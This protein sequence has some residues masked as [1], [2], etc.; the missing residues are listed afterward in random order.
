M[1]ID[2]RRFERRLAQLHRIADRS[3]RWR[4][5]LTRLRRDVDASIACH[6]RRRVQRPQPAFPDALP[7]TT[8]RHEIARTI[9]S[10]PV[11]V[12]C[13]D[14]GSGKT[15][16]LPKI[17]LALG[18]GASGLI[19]HT[20]PRRIAARSVAARIAEELGS[21]LGS[22][23]GYKVRFGDRVG[24]DA[25]IKIMTDGILLAEA[26]SDRLLEQYDTLIIDE[27]H[28][29]SLNIDF[30]LGYLKRLLKKRSDLKVIITSATIDPERF[31]RHFNNAPVIEV[32]GRAY[33]VEVLYRPPDGDSEDERERST[34]QAA[35]DAVDEVSAIDR[36]DILVFASGEREI[37]DLAEALRKHHPPHTEILPLYARLSVAEQNRVFSSHGTRRIVIA[38]NVAETSLTVPG[39]RYVIDIGRARVSRYSPRTQVQRLPIEKISQASAEQRKGRC[40]RVSAGICVRLYSENDYNDRPLFSEPEILRANLAGVILRMEA[41][42]L[43][44]VERFP[45]IDR[46][47]AKRIK[48]GFRLLAELGALVDG[49]LTD[50]GRQLARLPLDPRLGRMIFAA[51]EEHCLSEI[52]IIA[53]ALTVQDPRERPLEAAAKADAC[54][55]KFVEPRSDFVGFLKL[56]SVFNEQMHRLS[57]NKLRAF[58]RDNFLSY[59]RMQN[60]RDTH[61]QLQTMAKEMGFELN[62]EPAQYGNIHRAVLA[63]FLGNVAV[64]ADQGE[65]L[66]PRGGKLSLFPGSALFDKRPRWIVAAELVQTKRLYARTVATVEPEWVE[67]V[68]RDLCRRNYLE[69]HWDQKRGAVLAQEQV[70]LYGLV[71]VGDR[72]VHYGSIDHREA[73][74]I[75]IREGLIEGRYESEGAFFKHNQQLLAEIKALEHRT[76]RHDL[77][78]DWQCQYDFYDQRIPVG[79]CEATAFEHW[80]CKAEHKNA[81]LLYLERDYLLRQSIAGVTQERFPEQLAVNGMTFRLDYRFE[82]GHPADGVT[83][84][85]PVAAVNQLRCEPFDW[86]VPGLLPEKVAALLRS[87]PKPLRRNFVPIPKFTN[88]CIEALTPGDKPLT[89]ALAEELQRMTGVTVPSSAWRPESLPAHLQMNFRLVD[90]HGREIAVSRDLQCLGREYGQMASKGF[91][92]PVGEYERENVTRWDFGD[93]PETIELRAGGHKVKAYPAL[94]YESNSISLRLFDSEAKAEQAMRHGLR[95]LFILQLPQQLEYLR[96]NLPGIKKMCLHYAPIG[97]CPELKHDLITAAV[98]HVFIGDGASVRDAVI[99]DKRLEQGRADLI[100]TAE[101]LCELVGEVLDLYN[102]ITTRI[103]AIQKADWKR[104]ALDDIRGQLVRLVYAGFTQ[105]TPYARMGNLPRYLRAI[106][107]RLDKLEAAPAKDRERATD[108]LSLWHAYLERTEGPGAVD[109]PALAE[110]R[111]M[112]EELRVSLFAQE[113]KTPSPVSVK[114]L[115]RKWEAIGD[116]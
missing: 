24:R 56:W 39:I 45:F 55:R 42:R 73:R 74:S 48:D 116:R 101:K 22:D 67:Q 37:R 43:G 27:A 20:Q 21:E 107:S 81:R 88:A 30:I 2:R 115:K 75:F 97:S 14:T 49:E 110:Y 13:G 58:C 44:D 47:D 9:A 33:P 12:V 79:V 35:L 29:R 25:F 52:L 23:V 87:L 1:L 28:E 40:G 61:Q 65:Y 92:Q 102:T 71:I 31:S 69:P 36:G 60:W 63:G 72:R 6:E 94:M 89:K 53:S 85:V 86:L 78:A 82:P 19:G 50:M 109:S 51:R 108:M 76:R 112:L 57:R 5:A 84:T 98:D 16:Q 93:L 17:C 96:K 95:E 41:L 15:T 66:R 111:W 114:R 7:L 11:V 64:T 80:R 59:I 106:I 8:H 104:D 103:E 54:H 105:R 100:V 34:R 46:P 38:T 113:L 77:L 32:S 18:R 26:A 90:A 4:S 10:H 83:A 91:A 3:N 70:T 99:F 68:A 62:K